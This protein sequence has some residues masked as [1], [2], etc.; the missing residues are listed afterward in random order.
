MRFN[1]DHKIFSLHKSYFNIIQITEWQLCVGWQRLVEV[2]GLWGIGW[3]QALILVKI[4]A[5]ILN[6]KKS[7]ENRSYQKMTSFLLSHVW[8][9]LWDWD[10]GRFSL[11]LWIKIGNAND[12]IQKISNGRDPSGSKR[13]NTKKSGRIAHAYIQR[14]GLQLKA[15]S[16]FYGI[17]LL[18]RPRVVVTIKERYFFRQ[19]LK[20]NLREKCD[21]FD[22]FKSCFIGNNLVRAT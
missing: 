20:F 9:I 19:P 6:T 7:K 3:W 5:L 13:P 1:L 18:S 2:L 22:V 10:L 14:H 15:A 4:G 16:A 21:A 11:G 12:I 8:T 17:S